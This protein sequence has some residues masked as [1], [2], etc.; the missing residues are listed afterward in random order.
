MSEHEPLRIECDACVHQGTS[1]CDDCVV[2]F[3]L[4]REDGAVVVDADE[5]RALHSLGRAGLVPVL[6]LSRKPPD[7]PPA[8]EAG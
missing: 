5:A 8:E 2:T 1:Q 7:R 4:D 3:L 6:R